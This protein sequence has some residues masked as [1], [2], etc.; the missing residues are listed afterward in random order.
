MPFPQKGHGPPLRTRSG[1]GSEDGL[2]E[3]QAGEQSA[4]E[5]VEPPVV[6]DHPED[7]HE[8][9]ALFRCQEEDETALY[10]LGLHDH[11]SAPIAVSVGTGTVKGRGTFG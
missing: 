6:L 2:G 8:S 9:G 10:A 1:G 11:E 4:L 7:A 5:F 3:L